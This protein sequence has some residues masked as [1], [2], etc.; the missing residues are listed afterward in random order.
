MRKEIMAHVT[1]IKAS[2]SNDEPK[3]DKTPKEKILKSQKDSNEKSEE[4]ETKNKKTLTKADKKA[5][6]I[7]RKAEK[8]ANRKPA[9]K[10]LRVLAKPFVAI[11][12]YVHDSWLEIRQVRWP[13]RKATWKMVGAIFVYCV[14]AIV[15]VMLLDA[16]FNL[17]FSKLLG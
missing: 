5:L 17:I 1:K 7:Q 12:T 11:G 9:P 14:I 13:N 6:K 16:L 15:L 2:G 4:L 10:F 3:K 8:K